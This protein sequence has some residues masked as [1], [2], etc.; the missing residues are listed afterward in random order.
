[1][2]GSPVAW[3]IA[4]S[5]AWHGVFALVVPTLI[6][7]PVDA[8]YCHRVHASS[9]WTFSHVDERGVFVTLVLLDQGRCSRLASFPVLLRVH[10]LWLREHYDAPCRFVPQGD[11]A[12]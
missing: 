10:V 4:A 8:D 3:P 11:L 1:M 2:P 7:S 12:L 5:S 9:Q 6:S